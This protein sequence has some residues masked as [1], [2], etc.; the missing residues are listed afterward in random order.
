M[1][2]CGLKESQKSDAIKAFLSKM[3]DFGMQFLD[4]LNQRDWK[5]Q[6]ALHYASQSGNA[7][8][9][10][11]LLKHNIDVFV[12]DL[13]GQSPLHIAA[14]KG[15]LK[16]LQLIC[17]SIKDKEKEKNSEWKSEIAIWDHTDNDG[18]TPLHL[19]AAKGFNQCTDYL[20]S[21]SADPHIV[22]A[23]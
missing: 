19:C 7:F 3:M 11:L 20:L 5:L 6:T 18:R 9:V 16:I 17:D 15:C 10:G 2:A 23:R 13:N 21:I 8:V 12:F 14:K 22:D 4:K 1:I